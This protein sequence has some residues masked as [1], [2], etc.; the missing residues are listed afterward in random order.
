MDITNFSSPHL[1]IIFL[2]SS[3]LG[4]VP[5]LK[6]AGKLSPSTRENIQVSN[7]SFKKCRSDALTMMKD[8]KLSPK[9]LKRRLVG[10]KEKFPGASLYISCKK[11][12]LKTYKGKKAKLK[13]KVSECKKLLLATSFDAAN[14]IPFSLLKSQ[15]FFSGIGFNKPLSLRELDLPNFDCS[16]VKPAVKKPQN[17][18]FFLF[19]NHPQMFKAFSRWNSKKV[20]KRLGL[21]LEIP[22]DGH[23]VENLGKVFGNIR[24]KAATVYFPSASCVFSG[25]LGTNFTG[26]SVYYLIDSKR[27]LLLPYFSIAF[28][29]PNFSAISKT[30]M[31]EEVQKM[32]AENGS[33]DHKKD[34]ISELIDVIAT[35][36]IKEFDEEGD[37][38]NLCASPRKHRFIAVL[39]GRKN[40]IDKLEYLIMANVKNLC[41]FGDRITRL[42]R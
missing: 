7:R 25:P 40:E 1:I 36:K 41:S 38:R 20:S 26:L 19:G 42:F 35:S 37:P 15:Y 28:Y 29:H 2:I 30:Q 32:F 13:E 10:C 18:E 34:S 8:G 27:Q 12:A 16:K 23:Y 4:N 33:K 14:P 17:A 9:R 21:P 24:T 5:V 3:S 11:K 31:G 39:K 6:A 22:P